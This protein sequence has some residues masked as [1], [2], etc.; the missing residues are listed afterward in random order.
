M[1]IKIWRI[2]LNSNG[3]YMVVMTF[4]NENSIKWKSSFIYSNEPHLLPVYFG[5]ET[6]KNNC[7]Y[8]IFTHNATTVILADDKIELGNLF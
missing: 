3:S 4:R 5:I 7:V 2:L 6:G 8:A 1:S